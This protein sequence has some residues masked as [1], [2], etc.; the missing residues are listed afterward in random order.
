MGGRVSQKINKILDFNKKNLINFYPF[1]NNNINTGTKSN[2]SNNY[3]T[4]DGGNYLDLSR[5]YDSRDKKDFMD[6]ID[7]TTKEIV[8]KKYIF[9]NAEYEK[10]FQRDTYVFCADIRLT[11]DK[12]NILDELAQKHNKLIFAQ[13]N[14]QSNMTAGTLICIPKQ[15]FIEKPVVVYDEFDRF[16]LIA[17]VNDKANKIL[18]GSVY[19]RPSLMKT[20]VEAIE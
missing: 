17:Y 7:N 8:G 13:T 16:T 10:I 6:F 15:Y 19:M 9:F 2:P 12:K 1:K 14:Q 20:G 18:L 4:R 5:N 3:Y 11:N